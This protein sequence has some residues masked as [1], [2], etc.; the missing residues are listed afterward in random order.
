MVPTIYPEQSTESVKLFT[1]HR[2]ESQNASQ[3]N[4]LAHWSDV[5]RW[6]RFIPHVFCFSLI[7]MLGC[8]H[9]QF[10]FLPEPCCHHYCESPVYAETSALSQIYRM[11]WNLMR[12][13]FSLKITLSLPV[14]FFTTVEGEGG[15]LCEFLTGSGGDIMYHQS[16][17]MLDLSPFLLSRIL[18]MTDSRSP[19]FIHCITDI[20]LSSYDVLGSVLGSVNSIWIG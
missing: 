15:S 8:L 3:G 17:R 6:H 4:L 1:F 9:F 10:L 12:F 20:S 14:I 13:F 5:P 16:K 19:V 2:T 18:T 11:S 7:A